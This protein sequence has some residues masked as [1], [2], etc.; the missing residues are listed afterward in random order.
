MVFQMLAAELEARARLTLG[1]AATQIAV[2]EPAILGLP[3]P[4]LRFNRRLLA[5]EV[6]NIVLAGS[7]G[8]AAIDSVFHQAMLRL[9]RYRQ[10]VRPG[11]SFPR[12]C[13][14]PPRGWKT[15]GTKGKGR[16]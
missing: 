5:D 4:V 10:M 2:S 9:W 16:P 7:Q 13:I 6:V 1:V 14:S 11:R 15:R 12:Q 8:D 3:Q